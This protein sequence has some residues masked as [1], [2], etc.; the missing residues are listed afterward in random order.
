M[1]EIDVVLSSTWRNQNNR[2]GRNSGREIGTHMYAMTHLGGG[3]AGGQRRKTTTTTTTAAAAAAAAAASGHGNGSGSGRLL[4]VQYPLLPPQIQNADVEPD[5]LTEGVTT[6][7]TKRSLRV[8]HDAGVLELEKKKMK[9]TKKIKVKIEREEQQQYHPALPAAAVVG[10][11]GEVIEYDEQKGAEVVVEDVLLM[12]SG[13]ESRGFEAPHAPIAAA[14]MA[15]D[16]KALVLYPIDAQVRMRPVMEQ[17]ERPEDAVIDVLAEANETK[18]GAPG[19]TMMMARDGGGGG[20]GGDD[21]MGAPS[22]TGMGGTSDRDEMKPL[23]VNFAKRETEKDT[24]ARLES[25]AHIRSQEENDTWITLEEI[26]DFNADE[27]RRQA[28]FH[29]GAGDVETMSKKE[30]LAFLTASKSNSGGRA[31]KNDASG[32]T[33]TTAGNSAG[34]GRVKR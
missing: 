17:M 7:V 28:S 16:G 1:R 2:D 3:A 34:G 23:H 22:S 30:Y 27:N 24:R 25:Y 6:R 12:R 26:D 10:A 14:Q 18:L 20:G 32:A 15:S 31:L 11:G 13:A 21:M 33:P 19:T 4:L 9:M 29:H 8:K 5:V